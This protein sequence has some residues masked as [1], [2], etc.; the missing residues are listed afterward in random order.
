MVEFMV[1]K[2]V[3]LF[4]T[5]F[6]CGIPAC[7]VNVKELVNYLGE[8]QNSSLIFAVIALSGILLFLLFIRKK[9]YKTDNR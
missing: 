9:N 7:D 2:P 1:E 8:R 5:P 3:P 6:A 4:N